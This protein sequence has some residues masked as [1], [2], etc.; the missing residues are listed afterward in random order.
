MANDAAWRRRY[1]T[2]Q[3]SLPVWA[4]D[5]PARL[6][7]LSNQDGRFELY[8]WDLLRGCRRRLTDRPE[9]TV[10]GAIEPGGRSVWWFD[11]ERGSERGTWQVQPFDGGPAQPAAPGLPAAYQSGLALG[12]GV[13]VVG[14]SGEQ[15]S[16]VH[17]VEPGAPPL[18]LYRHA[19]YAAV[20]SISRHGSLLAVEHAEH[21]DSRHL[22][23]R[24]LS[25]GGEG[26]AELWDGPGLG[27]SAGD[28]SPLPSD[29]RLIVTHERGGVR[30]PAIWSPLAGEVRDLSLDLPGEV[31]A[32]WY[33]DADHLLLAHRYAGRG[34][35]YGCRL[36][37]GGLSEVSAPAGSIG[38]ARVRPDGRIWMEHSSGAAPPALLDGDQPLAINPTESA[39]AG[40]PYRDLRVGDVHGFWVEPSGPPPH[41][42]IFW[43]HGGPAAHDRDAFSP[44]VQAWVDHGFAVALVNY[45][46]STGYGRDWRDALEGNPGFTELEDLATVRAHLLSAGLAD[47]RR[48][49]LGGAS[50]GGYLTL[51]G[52]GTQPDSW[53]LGLAVVP[54]ADYLAAFEDEMEPLKAFDRAL[55][56]GTP[57][58][59]PGHYIDRSPITYVERVRVPVLV[60]AGRNDPRCPIR[61]IENYVSR[62]RELG[63][64]HQLYEFEAGHSSLVVEE[65]IRQM[66]L[67]LEFAHRHLGTPAPL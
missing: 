63:K 26:V 47:R 36:D 13:A 48:L 57:S 35:L 56:G 38:A 40:A 3:T 46:G 66:E 8:T 53:S 18:Q 62:L 29:Q 54:V 28:W 39:P 17:L 10:L 49:V 59:M 23:L 24:V 21:G 6:L 45:R 43:V 9:G 67:Q 19:E 14:T 16:A 60:V 1:R 37:T 52:L 65:Q 42:T 31:S 30:R 15:G 2:P 27:L 7:Y 44:R 64:P 22:A 4:D 41:P 50:W 61:Q 34:R 20:A 58:E 12:D 51:L 33:P 11:D 55:F 5:R 25:R 32:S